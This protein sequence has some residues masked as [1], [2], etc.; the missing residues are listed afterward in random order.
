MKYNW[1]QKDWTKFSYDISRLEERLY[2]FVEKSGR[3]SG[4]LKAMPKEAHEQTPLSYTH[5]RPHETLMILVSRLELE[6]K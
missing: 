2:A 6:K 3:I 1:Q 4:I 5:L